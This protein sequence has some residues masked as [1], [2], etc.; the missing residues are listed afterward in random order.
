[1]STAGATTVVAVGR[2][3]G[4]A[5]RREDLVAVL[6]AT[7]DAVRGQEGCLAYEFAA[8]LDAPADFLIVQRWTTQH[9]FDAH[10]ATEAHRTYQTRVEPLL[11][12]ASRL[13]VHRVAESVLPQDPRPIDPRR[14]D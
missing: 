11:R 7:Q 13:E 5:E 10:Y 12:E 14:A 9:A 3:F 6:R 4:E 8:V 2:I 1:M